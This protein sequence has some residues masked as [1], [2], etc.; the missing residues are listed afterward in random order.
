MYLQFF[1]HFLLSVKLLAAKFNLNFKLLRH[2]TEY[3]L[4]I[5]RDSSTLAKDPFER[6]HTEIS[7]IKRFPRWPQIACSQR[8]IRT[9]CEAICGRC[10]TRVINCN[11]KKLIKAAG[12][13]ANKTAQLFGTFPWPERTCY[14]ATVYFTLR[15]FGFLQ[16]FLLDGYSETS[17]SVSSESLGRKRG[18][19]ESRDCFH[20]FCMN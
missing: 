7:G 2:H 8:E 10:A 11:R 3:L 4:N 12:G 6:N 14:Y 5:V 17:V 9:F 13:L 1:W 19:S 16:G 18:A 15:K 20:L